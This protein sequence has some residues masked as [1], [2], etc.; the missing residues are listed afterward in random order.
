M[1]DHF[2]MHRQ[3][4]RKAYFGGNKYV[5]APTESMYVTIFKALLLEAFYT[6]CCKG[7]TIKSRATTCQNDYVTRLL[8]TVLE[9]KSK[10]V[11]RTFKLNRFEVEII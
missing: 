10:K 9:N 11:A 7:I 4:T 6:L 1:G 8:V 3:F 2:L 5:Y